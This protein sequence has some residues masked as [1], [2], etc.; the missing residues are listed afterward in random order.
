MLSN[1]TIHFPCTRSR[2]GAAARHGNKVS[3]GVGSAVLHVMPFVS[4]AAA[5]AGPYLVLCAERTKRPAGYFAAGATQ[6]MCPAGR[7]GLP[8]RLSRKLLL[9]FHLRH[10]LLKR[11][12]LS[13]QHFQ[14]FPDRDLIKDF[15]NV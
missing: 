7:A 13:G 5:A 1:L 9:P 4:L 15:H 11:L 12:D 3:V 6:F 8:R 14:R 2:T 10:T